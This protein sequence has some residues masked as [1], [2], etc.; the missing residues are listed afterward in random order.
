MV[1]NFFRAAGDGLEHIE[2]EVAVM[3]ASCRHSFDL[4][5]G[6]LVTDADIRPIGDEIRATDTKINAIEETVRRELVVHTAVQ[7]GAD[8]G[9][10]LSLL[11]VV[12]KLERVGDQAKNILNLAEEGV[13]FSDAEDYDRLVAYRNRVSTMFADAQRLLGQTLPDISEFVETGTTLM[14][15]CEAI[16]LSYLHDDSPSSYGV[17][18]AMLFRY[19]KRT[20][21]NIL[22]TIVTTVDGV[23]R[24]GD[25]DLD[26]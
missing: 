19:L 5:M 10:V 15:E 20:V 21:A 12:K 8:V 16:V 2:S 25:T 1:L 7:G 9:A 11:L 22:G 4:A 3:L 23:D 18:R 26:E 17:P 6:T 14:D 13:R 24:I